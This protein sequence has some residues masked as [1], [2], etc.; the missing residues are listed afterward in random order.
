MG[1][2]VEDKEDL[3]GVYSNS[4]FLMRNMKMSITPNDWP[5]QRRYLKWWLAEFNNAL[6]KSTKDVGKV[7]KLGVTGQDGSK[8]LEEDTV[9]E[10]D[11]QITVEILD[12]K[13][14]SNMI[15]A[16]LKGTKK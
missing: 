15:M 16:K 12:K 7:I 10:Q 14:Y 1:N 13:D 4:Q 8:I 9:K 6:F 3:N 2:T 5:S 11:L